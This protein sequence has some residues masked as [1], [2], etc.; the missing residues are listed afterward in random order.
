MKKIIFC[1]IIL[2]LNVPAWA[3]DY[4]DFPSN[5]QQILDERLAELEPNGGI[6][7]AGSVVMSD[8]SYI[9][10]GSDIKVNYYSGIDK[11]LWVY[12][13]GWFISETI[14]ESYAKG[15]KKVV[16][17]AFGYKPIDASVGVRKGEITY[18]DLVMDK[19]PPEELASVSGVVLDEKDKPL[20]GAT[21]NISFPLAYRVDNSQPRMSM[22]TGPDGKYYFEGLSVTEHHIWAIASGFAGDSTNVAT[23]PAEEIMCELKLYPK[24]KVVIDYVYQ[25]DGSRSF[26]GSEIETGTIEWIS[27]SHEGVDFSDGRAEG[28]EKDSLRDIELAQSGDKLEFFI[29][30]V[31]G[32]NGFSEIGAADFDSVEEA[33]ETTYAITRRPCVAGHV[34]VVKTYEGNYAKFIVTSISQVDY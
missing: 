13:D 22:T 6:C 5:L 2:F 10:S 24:L 26:V 9:G 33:P 17:R 8:G 23:R 3:I 12:A 32:T 34:Y 7:I 29:T 14:P 28:Y 31:N 1:L 11:P 25:A 18:V 20:E 21:V 15:S 16:L 30:Y 19:T 4:N 27:V